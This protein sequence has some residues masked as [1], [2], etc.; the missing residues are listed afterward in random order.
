[1]FLESAFVIREMKHVVFAKAFARSAMSVDQITSPPRADTA[2]DRFDFCPWVFWHESTAE[3]QQEQLEWQAALAETGHAVFGQRCFVSRLA[4][5]YPTQLTM[6]DS[7]F[8][9]AYAYV[10]ETVSMG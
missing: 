9:A 3:Q 4:G 7:A 2:Q 6:G 1:M 10:T 8:I 5:V